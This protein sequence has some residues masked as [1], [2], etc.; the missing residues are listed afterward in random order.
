M[1]ARSAGTRLFAHVRA[2]RGLAPTW[3]DGGSA[4]KICFVVG[5]RGYLIA[6]DAEESGNGRIKNRGREC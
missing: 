1:F 4:H 3:Q 2:L 5:G 6:G